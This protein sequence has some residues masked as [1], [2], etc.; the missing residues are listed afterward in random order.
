MAQL[1]RRAISAL[2][3]KCTAKRTLGLTL[4]RRIKFLSP[5]SL[6]WLLPV[7][8][9]FFVVE[10]EARQSMASDA[11]ARNVSNAIRSEETDAWLLAGFLCPARG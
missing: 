5:V 1:G 6:T 4:E 11:A 7:S 10:G 3:R 9:F 2:V 8:A